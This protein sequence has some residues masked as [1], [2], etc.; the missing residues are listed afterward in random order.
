MAN[1]GVRRDVWETVIA[2]I[3]VLGLEVVKSRV[4]FRVQLA[5][6]SK[7]EGDEK[8]YASIINELNYEITKKEE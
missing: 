5:I 4:A 2:M 8:T 3:E 1:L 6:D 7:R